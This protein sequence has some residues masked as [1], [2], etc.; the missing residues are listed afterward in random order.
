MTR[1]QMANSWKI[2]LWNQEQDKDAHSYHS[3]QHGIGSPRQSNQARQR[4][5]RY[6]NWKGRS[7]DILLADD[8]NFY[9]EIP[10]SKLLELINEFSVHEKKLTYKKSKC[11]DTLMMNF[12]ENKSILFI[13][14]IKSNK[15]LRNKFNQEG[16]ISLLWKLQ[17]LDEGNQKRYK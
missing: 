15:I 2:F 3:F 17:D 12:L 7:N 9:I 11:F 8:I 16:K 1:P 5:K 10:N 13:Y 14:S 4:K 6:Q